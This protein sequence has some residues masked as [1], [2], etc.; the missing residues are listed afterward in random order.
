[1]AKPGRNEPCHCQSGK[2]YKK[3][4]LDKDAADASARLAKDTAQN[5]EFYDRALSSLADCDDDRFV[6]ASNAVVDLV[7]AGKLDQAEAAAHALLADFPNMIDGLERLGMVYEK[8]CQYKVAADYYRKALA[9]IDECPHGFE[10]ASRDFYKE[11][12]AK[13]DLQAA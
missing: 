2:K 8:R 5:R 3:C 10:D 1:M 4:C 9:Y 11:K 6:E 12:I 13:L 7:Q